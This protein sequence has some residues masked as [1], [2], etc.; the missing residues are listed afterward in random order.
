MLSVLLDPSQQFCRQF[1]AFVESA[2]HFGLA[3]RRRFTFEQL[4]AQFHLS[5]PDRRMYA[6]W[7]I[8]ISMQPTKKFSLC[9]QTKQRLAIAYRLEKCSCAL[10]IRANLESN[11]S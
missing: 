9:L 5:L 11:D 7:K 4:R 1:V 2:L 6:H 10:I 8:T 3:R